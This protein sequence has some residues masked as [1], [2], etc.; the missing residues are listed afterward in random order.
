MRSLVLAGLVTLLVG[1][2]RADDTT[3]RPAA[4]AETSKFD[5]Q[6]RRSDR[7]I[8][9]RFTQLRAGFEA[10]QAALAAVFQRG[11]DLRLMSWGDGSGVPAS[12]QRLL[13]ILGIDNNG[14]LHIRRFDADGKL[15]DTDE[16]KLPPRKPGRSR[17]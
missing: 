4:S 6:G 14:R 12:G 9:E 10:Q 15:V 2:V 7:S 3:I 8:A 16:T 17:P 1:P 13:V 11:Y 5:D